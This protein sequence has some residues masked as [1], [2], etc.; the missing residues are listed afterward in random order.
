MRERESGFRYTPTSC[1]ETFPFPDPNDEQ[2]AAVAAAAKRLDDLRTNWLNPR[3]FVKME[4]MDFTGSVDGPWSQYIAEPDDDTGNGTVR[5]PQVVPKGSDA[6]KLLAK[7]TLTNLYNARPNW[8]DIAHRDLDSAV[9]A[10]YGWDTSM[11]DEAV[12]EALLAL[13]LARD[14]AAAAAAEA[15][16]M[17]G[18]DDEDNDER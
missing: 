5:Y 1:F 8:L 11:S 2:Q 15:G 17:E 12:L 7:R 6:A 9:F 18:P 13:N 4:V 10:A 14:V 16:D 3:E